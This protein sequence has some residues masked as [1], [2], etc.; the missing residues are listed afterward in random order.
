MKYFLRVF[1]CQMN[2]SDS[3][4]LRTVL[5]KLHY[6]KTDIENEADLIVIVACAVRQPAVDRI[7][8]RAKR[9]QSIKNIRPLTTILTGCVLEH[10]KNKMI[11]V[12]D[13]IIPINDIN[14]L[15]EI[16]RPKA[17]TP[18]STA[19]PLDEYFNILPQ[20]NS[21]FQAFVPISSGC[22]KFCSYCAVPY[23]RGREISRPPD[24][25]FNE[26]NDLI[27]K[28]YKEITLLGQNVNSY[29]W[30][31]EG[32]SINYPKG[33]VLLHKKSTEGHIEINKRV[34]NNPMSFPILLK[35]ISFIPGDFWIRFITSHPYDMD[36]ELI[37][38]I[39]NNKKITPYIHLAVQSGSNK[40][41]RRMN[42]LYTIEHY[43]KRIKLIRKLIPNAVISTDII[44]G[45]SG[46][47]DSDFD[48]TVQLVKE[49]K[50][51]MAYIAQYSPRPGTLGE[52]L[53]DDVPHKL[54]IFRE[55]TLNN[56]LR[57]VALE[58]NKKL[59]SSTQKVLFEKYSNGYCYGKTYG[60]KNIKVT[61]N[62]DCVGNF[63]NVL[64]NKASP[65]NLSG[66]IINNEKA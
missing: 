63:Y 62:I 22:N 8:G 19:A 11:N 44:V 23:T 39:S 53:P 28:G 65:W 6:K 47:T 27:N 29:G 33:K 55:Y 54:K 66:K 32:V 43:K 15:P 26:V 16:L 58:N 49:I 38:A 14:R 56:A 3:E 18:S 42:R 60:F 9:W 61:A 25:I 31:F 41:L 21:D 10:D 36:D 45:Y 12:F 51:D 7:Y 17:N 46:E 59:V 34:V 1:G 4:R 20:Y 57:K 52:K 30:D 50:F 5:D 40:V 48:K 35:N 37:N 2:V 64:I 13:H 24:N